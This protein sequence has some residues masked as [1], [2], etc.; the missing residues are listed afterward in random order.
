M[1]HAWERNVKAGTARR[2]IHLPV[3]VQPGEG[4]E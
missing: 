3:R 1:I 4:V 2:A